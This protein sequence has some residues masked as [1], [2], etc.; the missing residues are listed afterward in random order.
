MSQSQHSEAF[1]SSIYDGDIENLTYLA[2]ENPQVFTPDLSVSQQT[3]DSF[4][5]EFL[6]PHP[7][8]IIPPS[9]TR[10]GPDRRKAYIL[11]EIMM[12][13]DFVDWW[14]QT[15]YGKSSKIRW[16]SNHQAET[17][18]QYHQVAHSSDGAAK[19]MCKRCGQIL[20]HPSSLRPGTTNRHGTSTM[21]KHLRS[22]GCLKASRSSTKRGEITKFIQ[23]S[24]SFIST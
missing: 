9:L 17:W 14:L 1:S 19:V 23:V 8:L 20:E 6:R 11:Y 22:A 5:P 13:S 18:Q 12:H 16:D 7:P 4:N 10:V 24:V 15:D 3:F 2:P 21:I